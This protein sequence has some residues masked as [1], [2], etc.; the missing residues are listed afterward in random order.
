MAYQLPPDVEQRVKDRMAQGGYSSADEVL[1]DALRA[2]DEISLFRCNPNAARIAS[3]EQLRH[4][5][6]RGVQ[7]LD[8]G[9]GR[10]ADEV[11][12]ELLSD[13]PESDQG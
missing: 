5:V 12:D 8:R 1:R 4:E 11:F 9:E 7:Q 2:L 13:L 6:C 10:D 3:F